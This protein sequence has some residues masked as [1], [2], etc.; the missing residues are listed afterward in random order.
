VKDGALEEGN[1][2]C[3]RVSDDPV[4]RGRP[5]KTKPTFGACRVRCTHLNRLVEGISRSR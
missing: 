5:V 4:V 3:T 1:L 2:H